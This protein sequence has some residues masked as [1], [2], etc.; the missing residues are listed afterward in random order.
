MVLALN[1]LQRAFFIGQGMKGLINTLFEFLN[2]EVEL[3]SL[4][5]SPGI[6]NII[7]K[8]HIMS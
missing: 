3:Q 5:M 7:H 2:R 4:H 1:L 8:E 6:Q